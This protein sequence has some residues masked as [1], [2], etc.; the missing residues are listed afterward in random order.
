[1][2]IAGISGISPAVRQASLVIFC[3]LLAGCASEPRRTVTE[4]AR[5]ASADEAARLHAQAAANFHRER[6][7]QE[8]LAGRKME[9]GTPGPVTVQ[10]SALPPVFEGPS[11]EALP[12]RKISPAE[13]RYAMQIGKSP[14]ELTPGERA[15]A[16]GN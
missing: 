13:A 1:L 3:A 9:R 16:L 8:V 5:Y 14:F 6:E 4:P 15:V 2:C 7:R 11:D 10:A 12:R